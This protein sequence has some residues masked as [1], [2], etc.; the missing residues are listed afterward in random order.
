MVDCLFS[1]IKYLLLKLTRMIP[2][3]FILRFSIPS[4]LI[5]YFCVDSQVSQKV[6]ELIKKAIYSVKPEVLSSRIRILSEIDESDSVKNIGNINCTYLRALDDKLVPKRC[7]KEFSIKIKHSKIK[8]LT[9]GHFILQSKPK[10]SW[11]LIR[12]TLS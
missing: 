10:E 8:E 1:E 2:M 9:G 4:F 7:G 5:R 3:S 11:E 12:E 6:I